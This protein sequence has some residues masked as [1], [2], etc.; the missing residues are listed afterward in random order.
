MK[1]RTPPAPAPEVANL[2]VTLRF[3]ADREVS[4]ANHQKSLVRVPGVSAVRMDDTAKTASVTYTGDYKGLAELG[5]AL[6]GQGAVV[7]PARLV[8]RVSG[9]GV[10]KLLETLKQVRGVKRAQAGVDGLEFWANLAELD[11]GALSGLGGRLSFVNSDLIEVSLSA[12]GAEKGEELRRVLMETR[13]V[14]H[15]ELAGSTARI[16]AQKG[17]VSMDAI[18]KLAAPLEVEVLP[19]KK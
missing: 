4:V 11:L 2:T 18:R 10:P 9:A 8:A 12:R 5:T 17:K 1:K 13:G 15:V 16:L 6:N 14:L 7:D 19:L 3:W